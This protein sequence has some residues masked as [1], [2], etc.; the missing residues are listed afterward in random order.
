MINFFTDNLTNFS[1]F[2][3]LS[4]RP[5]PQ[6]VESVLLQPGLCGGWVVDIGVE[7]GCSLMTERQGWQVVLLEVI[8]SAFF[9]F[10]N[11]YPSRFW[12][13]LKVEGATSTSWIFWKVR[14]IPSGGHVLGGGYL[15]RRP[16]SLT[17]TSDISEFIR[18]ILPCWICDWFFWEFFFELN[19][20]GYQYKNEILCNANM[21]D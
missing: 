4:L 2:S 6:H 13:V 18:P 16:S 14:K 3:R 21:W 12:K 15:P 1:P 8:L 7:V 19:N 11:E 9:F 10:F 20:L 17:P 5:S